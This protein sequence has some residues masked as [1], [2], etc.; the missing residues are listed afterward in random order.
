MGT[1]KA[2]QNKMK[3]YTLKYK[4]WVL[5]I[6]VLLYL[7]I[8]QSCS[9]DNE[10]KYFNIAFKEGNGYVSNSAA[11]PYKDTAKV[12]IHVDYILND[13]FCLI[14]KKNGLEDLRLKEKRLNI[15][16]YFIKQYQQEERYTF[17]VIGDAGYTDSLTLKLTLENN[18]Y[19]DTFS[20]STQYDTIDT[21]SFYSASSVTAYSLPDAYDKQGDVD[22]FLFY[23]DVE[24]ALV[25]A[26]PA[27]IQ[28]DSIF[29]DSTDVRFWDTK[30]QSLIHYSALSE[31][32]YDSIKTDSVLIFGFDASACTDR[33]T[34]FNP[35]DII[36]F[37]TIS[38]IYGLLKVLDVDADN[39]DATIRFAIKV[40]D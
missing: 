7:F 31:A 24:D 8:A 1:K 40:Q 29:D 17:E 3:A 28:Q 15:E 26:S 10:E 5:G 18:I 23:D 32:D 9:D 38:D 33:L 25:L 30:N 34:D 20:L 4:R 35:G 13:S 2:E 14:I 21:N 22:L 12:G 6:L 27:A 37:Y 11:L 36:A 19:T 39:R 16:L